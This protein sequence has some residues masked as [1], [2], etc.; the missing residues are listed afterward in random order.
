MIDSVIFEG[1]RVS[2]FPKIR[3]GSSFWSPY[4]KA[5]TISQSPGRGF[6]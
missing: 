5:P 4:N 1:F 6:L 3:W 2:E